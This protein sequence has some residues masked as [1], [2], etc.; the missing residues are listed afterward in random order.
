[1]I[2]IRR[3]SCLA[4]TLLAQT[5]SFRVATRLVQVNVI[6]TDHR[7]DPVTGLTKDTFEIFDRGRPQ[8][9]IFFSE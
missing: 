3:R 1:L 7:G 4:A 5:P 2:D 6:V 9:L 8:K